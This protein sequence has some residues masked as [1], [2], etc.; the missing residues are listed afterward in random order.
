MK[1]TRVG[2]WALSLLLVSALAP[3][4][5]SAQTPNNEEDLCRADEPRLDKYGY[6]R[7]LYL[8]LLGTVPSPQDYAQLD[9]V[10]D[11][12]VEM[13]EQMLD[14]D[15]FVER[16]VR[17]HR[18]FLWNNVTNVNLMNY[19][20]SFRR[21]GQ[22]YW[23][24]R[25]ALVYRG[26]FVP[27]RDEPAQFD[28]NGEIVFVDEGNGVRREGYVEVRP[29]WDPESLI[30][31]CASDA[32]ENAV[33]PTGADCTTNSGFNDPKCGCGPELG[34]CRYGA[35]DAV[36][37]S[38]G[39]DV[40]MRIAKIIRED[41]PYTD[42]FTS[43]TA[44]VD[45]PI[46]H[47]LKRQRGVPANVT[48]EPV[49]YDLD[50]LPELAYTADTYNFQQIE[51][52]EGHAGVLTSPAYLLR[53]QTNRARANRFFEA[54]LCA[55]FSPP[56]GGL[57]GGDP[58]ALPHPDLQQREG[59]RYCHALLEPAAAHWGR[60]AERGAGFLDAETFPAERED[61][62]TC[63][64]TGRLCSRECRLYYVTRPLSSVE[65]EFAGQLNAYNFLR[66]SHQLNVDLGPT[67]L[68]NTAIVD[69]RFPRC[70]A[71]RAM[72]GLFGRDLNTEERTSLEAL[73]RSFVASN[74]SYKALVK[75]IVTSDV[76]RRVR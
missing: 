24:Y 74:Y 50:R 63:A 49:A 46:V 12:P 28:A 17:I 30:R 61:C 25:P 10:D 23:R 5:A 52:P 48:L 54:F 2:G 38:L 21:T 11:V 69:D 13:I 7:S 73:G 58:N 29:Y 33:S 36:Q 1:R 75:A 59:C 65:M 19:R 16:A 31:V 41:L 27:C 39:I 34:L 56:T 26:D 68:V 14:T 53:F 47:Y 43:R 66:E 22:L 4:G 32:Q 70:S 35:Y 55:P 18:S 44:F 42:L 67:H 9:G 45:G 64:M 20:T 72:E 40:D 15:A 37:T 51:L 62:K 71:Q 60:W 3:A 6:L 57:P 76:Y 8:D